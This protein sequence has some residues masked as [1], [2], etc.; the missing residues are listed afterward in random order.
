LAIFATSRIESEGTETVRWMYRA[1][2]A[3]YATEGGEV[4][5]ERWMYR[6]WCEEN[7]S[8]GD[9][10]RGGG[11]IR[12]KSR[13]LYVYVAGAANSLPGSTISTVAG[14]TQRLYNY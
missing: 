11:G 5:W 12:C 1:R 13:V 8:T 3:M 9:G 6:R 2:E 14:N 7:E 4:D 10:E